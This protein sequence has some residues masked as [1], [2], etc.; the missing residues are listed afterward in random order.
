MQVVLGRA[1]SSGF[2]RLL[3]IG[4]RWDGTSLCDLADGNSRF[5][6]LESFGGWCREFTMIFLRDTQRVGPAIR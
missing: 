4:A 6:S 2:P 1:V 3:D 5:R